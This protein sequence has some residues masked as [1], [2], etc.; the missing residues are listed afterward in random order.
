[1]SHKKVQLWILGDIDARIVSRKKDEIIKVLTER[2][3]TLPCPRCGS[4]SFALLGGYFNQTVETQLKDINIGGITLPTAVVTCKQ[5][6][7]LSQ[8]AL[9]VLGLL[10]E[11]KTQK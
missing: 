3:A 1:M 7:Y 9:A 2:G 11:E 10:N 6:G 8:H 4:K 5:C